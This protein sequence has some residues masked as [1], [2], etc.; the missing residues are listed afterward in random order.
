MLP[1]ALSSCPDYDSWIKIWRNFMNKILLGKVGSHSFPIRSASN[2]MFEDAQMILCSNVT[3]QAIESSSSLL[4]KCNM[5]L[6][7]KV[8]YVVHWSYTVTKCSDEL[9]EPFGQWQSQDALQLKIVALFF[10]NAA[11][12]SPTVCWLLRVDILQLVKCN[13]VSHEQVGSHPFQYWI[14]PLPA[15]DS[16]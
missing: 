15:L 4:P 10:Q 14:S 6:L 13:R 11:C 7:K 1:I 16:I 9:D 3:T 12:C 2:C 8:Q 5:F